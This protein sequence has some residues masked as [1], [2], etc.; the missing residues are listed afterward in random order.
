MGGKV[1]HKGWI[2][3]VIVILIVAGGAVYGLV[4]FNLSALQDPG[5]TETYIAS[6]FREWYIRR[7]AGKVSASTVA[8][9]ATSIGQGEGL[10]SMECA[11]C[12]G[13]DGR[14]PTPVGESMYPRVPNLSSSDTQEMADKELFWVIKNGIRFSGMP[15]FAKINTDPEV[16]QL[17]YYVRSLGLPAK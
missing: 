15:G 7:G 16:W 9:D 2:I 12:H 4:A 10:Y 8:N 13:P 5:G 3:A 14:K 1:A 11:Q 17:T 6:A